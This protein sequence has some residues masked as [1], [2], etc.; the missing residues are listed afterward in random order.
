MFQEQHGQRG[1]NIS[2]CMPI[3][4]D[5]ILQGA[6]NNNT[7]N[8]FL[9]KLDALLGEERAFLIMD[10]CRIHYG[11]QGLSEQHSV[12]Y[13]PPYSPFLNPIES[14]FSSLK[15]EIKQEVSSLNI[16]ILS[17][18]DRA[19]KFKDTLILASRICFN[20]LRFIIFPHSYTSATSQPQTFSTMFK[21]GDLEGHFRTLI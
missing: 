4:V 17:Q 16:A 11:L 19:R 14:V 18:A 15:A 6:F 1:K 20:C 5:D 9:C 12:H 21:S 10:N 2:L 7:F 3:S 8:D 13:L